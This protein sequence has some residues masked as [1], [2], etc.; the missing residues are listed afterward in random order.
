[1]L[2]FPG[3]IMT[4]SGTFQSHIYSNFELTNIEI[5]EFQ[6]LIGSDIGT[7]LDIFTEP[8]WTKEQ[9]YKSIEVTLERTQQACEMKYDMMINGVVQGSIYPDLREYCAKRMSSMDVDVHPIG[10][11]VPLMEQYLYTDLVNIVMSSK[12][13]LNPSRPVHLFGA[14]HPMILALAVIMGCDL[15]DSSSYA[16]FARDDRMMFVDGTF[17]LSDMEQLNCKCPSCIDLTIEDLRNMNK[18]NRTEIIARHN[19]N[20]IIQ[21]LS[22]IHR[23]ICE[24]R[25]WELVEMR[26]RAHPA[27]LSALRSLKNYQYMM[28]QYDPISRDGAMFYTGPESRNRPVFMRY[29][30]RINTR[31]IPP[32]PK[33]VLFKDNYKKPYNKYYKYEFDKALKAGYT[34]IVITPFGPV[35]ADLD[36]V[37]P[38]T[39]S[40][41]P[42]IVDM[43]TDIESKR[44]TNQFL[45]SVGFV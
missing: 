21:E 32:T 45:K 14:G 2:D 16:K 28:E 17:R 6:K 36:E 29:L 15:F 38:I 34:P 19:L 41:F 4:D 39:Q 23:Y 3:I 35:P 1:M 7:V 11:I 18:K 13:G 22:L 10:G 9:T 12:K 42:D 33:A 27:I 37:Y 8:Y 24:G 20:Q 5:L 40:L 25:L 31:Y 30:N 44:A 43:E 26:C